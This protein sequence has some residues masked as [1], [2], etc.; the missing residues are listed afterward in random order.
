MDAV[1]AVQNEKLQSIEKRL[2][3]HETKCDDRQAA[4]WEEFRITRS[5]VDGLRWWIVG[6]V[7]AGLAGDA[8]I[9]GV[10]G[11]LGG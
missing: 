3:N 9:S 4:V 10:F 8:G 6:A 7:A 1:D 2:D 11:L 5:R